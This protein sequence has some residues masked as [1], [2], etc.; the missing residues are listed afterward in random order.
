[1]F[2]GFGNQGMSG[3]PMGPIGRYGMPPPPRMGGRGQYPGQPRQ[4]T[5]CYS[6]MPGGDVGRRYRRSADE[7]EGRFIEIH[8]RNGKAT[9]NT[10][11]PIEVFVSR[12]NITR[13]T[14]LL[15]LRASMKQLR[16][17]SR[18]QVVSGDKDRFFRVHHRDE[19]SVLHITKNAI[20]E[21]GKI[22]LEPGVYSLILKAT[23]TLD[24]DTILRTSFESDT[25][26]EAIEESVSLGVKIFLED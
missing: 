6:C 13:R 7:S 15:E 24:H 1:M 9:V 18:Y 26:Q 20:D 11:Y 4:D 14:P 8:D 16:D 10:T 3:G 17:H 19:N 12:L 23:T 5:V 25:I 21:N 2:P 22:N